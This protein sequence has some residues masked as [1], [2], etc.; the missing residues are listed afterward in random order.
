MIEF[1][2]FADRVNKLLFMSSAPPTAF[3][4]TR[5][6]PSAWDL[7]LDG[8]PSPRTAKLEPLDTYTV[9]LTLTGSALKPEI[10]EMVMTQVN[11]DLTADAIIKFF[12]Q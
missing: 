7:Q 8:E 9:R 6:G 3:Q 4:G 10:R 2:V 11:A 1:P 5:R 12:C